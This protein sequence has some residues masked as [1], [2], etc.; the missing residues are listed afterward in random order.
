MKG[1]RHLNW[2]YRIYR[3][4]CEI[5]LQQKLIAEIIG[6]SLATIYNEL[7]RGKF[8]HLKSDL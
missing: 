5:A 4:T 6:C 3:K 8:T 1:Y 2:N 7:N